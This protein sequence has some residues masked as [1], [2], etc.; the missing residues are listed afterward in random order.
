M[1]S[2]FDNLTDAWESFKASCMSERFK[3]A[4]PPEL[5]KFIRGAFY[6]GASVAFHAITEG[7]ADTQDGK[8]ALEVFSARLDRMDSEIDAVFTELNTASVPAGTV[9]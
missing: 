4:T 3:R 1:P 7:A 2:D 5:M 6:A 9:Q 8:L